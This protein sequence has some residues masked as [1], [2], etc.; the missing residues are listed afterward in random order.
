MSNTDS[1]DDRPTLASLLELAVRGSLDDVRVAL[2]GR[3]VSYDKARQRADVQPLVG[4]RIEDE[5]GER[6]A[7]KLPQANDVPIMFLGAGGYSETFPI[8]PGDT[9]LLVFC[10]SSIARWKQGAAQDD[11]D[12]G[13][14]RHHHPADAV[15]YA[16]VRDASGSLE[17]VPGDA[18]CITV[19]FGRR[20]LLGGSS[21]A[22]SV[23]RGE[24][25]SSALTKL[26]AAIAAG[27]GAITPAP[28][29]AAAAA[30]FTS[31]LGSAGYAADIAALLSTKVKVD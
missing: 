5:A 20:I 30:A 10:S 23:P 15:A 16:G 19:P 29:G 14:D 12:P 2:P 22:S 28:I 7:V 18:W 6:Q 24:Q 11:G 25:L 3:V 31:S 1:D 27:F 9:V 26:V 21:S 4:D 17:G 8:E 13:D